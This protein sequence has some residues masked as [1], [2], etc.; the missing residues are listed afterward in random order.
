MAPVLAQ[1][2]TFSRIAFV[3]LEGQLAT[4]QPDGSDLVLLTR[5]DSE[6]FRFPAWSPDGQNLAAVQRGSCCSFYLY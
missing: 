6:L 1:T 3:T 4:V 2:G 5:G